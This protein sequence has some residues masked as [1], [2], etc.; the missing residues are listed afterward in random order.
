[1][2]RKGTIFFLY[3]QLLGMNG[4]NRRMNGKKAGAIVLHPLENSE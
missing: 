3:F 1:M 2:R 4:G